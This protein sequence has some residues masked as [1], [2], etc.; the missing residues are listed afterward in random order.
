MPLKVIKTSMYNTYCSV[1]ESGMAEHCFHGMLLYI[2][3]K[4]NCVVKADWE[5]LD[6]MK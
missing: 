2:I 4:K 6:E 3:Q 1:Y 5:T